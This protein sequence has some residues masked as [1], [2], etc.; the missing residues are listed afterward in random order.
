M[1]SLTKEACYMTVSEKPPT[2]STPHA[3]WNVCS[4]SIK[5]QLTQKETTY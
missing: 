5:N 4:L 3:I 1:G 2:K